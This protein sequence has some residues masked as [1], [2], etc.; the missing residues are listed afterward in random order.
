[1]RVTDQPQIHQR[2]RRTSS[3]A[4]EDFYKGPVIPMSAGLARFYFH[5]LLHACTSFLS[6]LQMKLPNRHFYYCGLISGAAQSGTS[7]LLAEAKDV[8]SITITN[9]ALSA[10]AINRSEQEVCALYV[11][12]LISASSCHR[13]Y[14]SARK[15]CNLYI[16][17]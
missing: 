3:P 6:V 2:V 4:C 7:Q 1:M 10:V 15:K 17:K 14:G 12:S 11:S 9:I 8:L 5:R 13:H 16:P